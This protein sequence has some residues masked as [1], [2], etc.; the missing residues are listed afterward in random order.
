MLADGLV[1]RTEV[2]LVEAL[3]H[4]AVKKVSDAAVSNLIHIPPVGGSAVCVEAAHKPTRKHT[5]ATEVSSTIQF[6]SQSAFEPNA[7]KEGSV[8]FIELHLNSAMPSPVDAADVA[9]L[10]APGFVNV[11]TF[12][13]KV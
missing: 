2:V 1:A 8:A 13:P 4:S 12:D 9:K 7:P 6:I 10:K 11:D 3:R 5:L